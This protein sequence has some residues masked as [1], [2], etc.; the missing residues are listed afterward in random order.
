MCPDLY[1]IFLRVMTNAKT[2]SNLTLAASLLSR[3]VSRFVPIFGTW[4]IWDEKEGRLTM[5]S[6]RQRSRQC[7]VRNLS[8]SRRVGLR[9]KK[10]DLHTPEN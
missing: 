2:F 5:T 6:A 10:L 1:N 3:L 9:Q 8:P 4:P 7:S